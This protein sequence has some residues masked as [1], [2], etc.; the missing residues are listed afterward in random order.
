[1]D[2]AIRE[3]YCRKL[4]CSF[5]GIQLPSTQRTM[6]A[7]LFRLKAIVAILAVIVYLGSV[8]GGA[9]EN[10]IEESGGKSDASSI[11]K[12]A[13]SWYNSPNE[14]SKSD[15]L[16]V[17]QQLA[18][19]GNHVLS[20]VKLG[21]HFVE[22]G[23]RPKA[24][25][26]FA[27]AGESGPHHQSLYNA[28]RLLAEQEDWVGALAYLKAAATL[29]QSRPP[30]YITKETTE[31]ALVAHEIVVRTLSRESLSLV[32]VVDIFVYGSLVDLPEEARELWIQAV[33]GFVKL[34]DHGDKFQ[35]QEVIIEVIQCLRTL[36]EK[37]GS[38]GSLSHIQTYL[39]LDNIND[40]LSLLIDVDDAF[41]PMAAGY[42]EALA[43]RSVYCYERFATA[44]DD[45]RDCFDKAIANA[46]SLYRRV[47]DNDS[48]KRVLHA[49]QQHPQ[50][51][52]DQEL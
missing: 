6:S 4:H 50:A 1:M 20:A 45:D 37:Y 52:K 32:Q 15:A 19:T 14:K 27:Q 42:A 40:M 9:I 46:L 33:Q 12:V 31:A 38:T 49:A 3:P 17:L 30:E 8:H 13:L 22:H 48:I 21:H 11:Y 47:G 28:G 44:S 24:I 43:T 5:I 39:L 26:Y 2:D 36:W 35:S 29:S 23:N 10:A 16:E 18:D 34:Q 41:V 51:A 7:L 25:Q